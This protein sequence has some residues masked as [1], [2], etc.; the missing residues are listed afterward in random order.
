MTEKVPWY[1]LHIWCPGFGFDSEEN[2]YCDE[3]YA[4]G[5]PVKGSL[6]LMIKAPF[7]WVYYWLCRR[8]SSLKYRKEVK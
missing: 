8:Y 4:G 2:E 6:I 3:E 5:C 1:C 7:A